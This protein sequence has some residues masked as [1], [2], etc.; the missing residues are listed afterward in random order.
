MVIL[1]HF[2]L[3]Q[4]GRNIKSI[5]LHSIP[6]KGDIISVTDL[7]SPR[8]LVLRVEFYESSENITLHVKEFSNQLSA[9]NNIDGFDNIR[10]SN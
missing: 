5:D 9:T 8:Y 2:Y 3:R 7:K 1:M 6:R 10:S 4:N